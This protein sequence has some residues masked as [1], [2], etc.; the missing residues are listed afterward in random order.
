MEELRKG[1]N[2]PFVYLL[3]CVYLCSYDLGNGHRLL[4]NLMFPV[5]SW[6]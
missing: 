4:C 2:D 6:L 5:V 3:I 1:V